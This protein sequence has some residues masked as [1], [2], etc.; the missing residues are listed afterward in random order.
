MSATAAALTPPPPPPHDAPAAGAGAAASASQQLLAVAV[1]AAGPEAAPKASPTKGTKAPPASA[2]L[3]T[4]RKSGRQPDS[5]FPFSFFFTFLLG[6]CTDVHVTCVLCGS[7]LP[8][9]I[10]IHFMT[11]FRPLLC[12]AF[13]QSVA[14]SSVTAHKVATKQ[15]VSVSAFVFQCKFKM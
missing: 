3:S 8:F 4:S 12:C 6:H 13:F 11:I 5:S 10:N 15:Q 9:V 1:V 7:L 2:T 14:G